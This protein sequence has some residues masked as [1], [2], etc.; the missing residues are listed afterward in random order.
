MIKKIIINVDDLGLSEA[1]NDAVVALAQAKKITASSLMSLGQIKPDQVDQLHQHKID[2][3]LHV[4]FTSVLFQKIHQANTFTRP[5]TLKKL[6]FSAWTNWLDTH[7]VREI[8]EEQLDNFEKIVGRI[9]VFIDGH[10]H[11][12][13]FPQ[14][15]DQLFSVL[16]K[17]YPNEVIAIRS[18]RAISGQDIKAQVIYR[19]GGGRL[20]K[21]CAEHQQNPQNKVLAGAYDFR[22]FARLP[23]YWERWLKQLPEEKGLVMC[24]PA[25]MG[26][27]WQD[28]I[29]QARQAEYAWLMSAKFDYLLDKYQVHLVNWSSMASR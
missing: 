5:N 2:I 27:E 4:D 7:W 26:E 17:R 21:M 18:T 15:R 11:V 12:H 13:Q 1:V 9:P 29:L 10:Q 16:Q 14:I 6:I 8:I 23:L 22:F 19:L 28:E 3:G 24:H 20:D 25:L